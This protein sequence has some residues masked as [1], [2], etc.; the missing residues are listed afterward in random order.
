MGTWCSANPRGQFGAQAGGMIFTS[1]RHVSPR[2]W[3][4]GT[5]FRERVHPVPGTQLFSGHI[6]DPHKEGFGCINQ[7]YLRAGV[8]Y[9]QGSARHRFSPLT[10]CQHKSQWAL[11]LKSTWPSSCPDLVHF[12]LP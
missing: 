10:P 7:V 11:P 1:T 4:E 8:P 2:R 9:H 3:L 12:H 6:G 5:G